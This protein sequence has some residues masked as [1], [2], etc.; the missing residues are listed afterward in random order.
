[1]TPGA[2]WRPMGIPSR[3]FVLGPSRCQSCGDPVW[4]GRTKTRVQGETVLGEV[5][6]WREWGRYAVHR[7]VRLARGAQ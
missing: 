2:R 6:T 4:F 7:C 3:A 5:R 1:M